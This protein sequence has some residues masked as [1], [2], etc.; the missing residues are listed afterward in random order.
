VARVTTEGGTV[1][2]E[3]G[4]VAVRGARAATIV[5]GAATDYNRDDPYKALADDPAAL[6]RGQ[7]ERASA[8]GYE[9]LKEASVADHQSLFRRVSLT[10]SGGVGEMV[11]STGERLAA[12]RA[13]ATDPGLEALYFQYGRYLLI[14]S[15]RPGDQPANLQGI[16]S[17]HLEAPWNAD[18]HVNINLQMNY[19]HAE[20]ANLA[21]CAD[22]FFWYIEGVRPAGREM[23]R[24]L[25]CRGFAMG[26][27]GD[28]W[29]WTAAT[30]EPVWGMWPQGAGWCATHFT[31][32][33]RFAGDREFLEKRAYPVLKEC[34]EFYL[35]WLEEEPGTGM[36]V[37][38]PE[39]SPEN[40]YRE[41]GKGLSQSM[42]PAMSQEIIAQVFGD[43]L[44]AAKALGVEDEFTKRVAG[45]MEKLARP[46]VG[47][48]GRLMEWRKEYE[49]PE[50]GHRHMS[51]LF[52]LYPGNTITQGKTPELVA[53]ARKSLD[54]RLSHGGGHT[55][56]SRAWLINFF[57]RLRDGEGAHEHLRLLLA[58][59]TLPNLFDD[60]PP[61]QIDGNFGG[62]AGI[63]EMLLQSH[64]GVIDV[65]PAL[66]KAWGQGSV[67]GLK[68]RGNFTVDIEWKG[69]V[70]TELAIRS[71]LGGPVRVRVRGWDGEGGVREYG[72][73]VEAKR[74]GNV[75]EFETKAGGRYTLV[76]K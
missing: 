45:A 33:W 18:Y 11:L 10:L 38:G 32:H 5:I 60:H 64:D 56:W 6:A 12:V 66:P 2:A 22:P 4:R 51:H 61:F 67:K 3:N 1:R 27:E 42:G 30:G 71:N 40:S 39:T 59:S 76:P 55:G 62:A 50:P 47:K 57:A 31:E 46:T 54:Y 72:R 13:G 68:A 14:C 48:D 28:A 23:A 15:S 26:H 53:A 70:V 74:L 58:K 75:I 63:A 16:W 43:M 52:G 29:L 7:V 73:R 17:E 20:V 41:G 69:G 37:S 35:D 8:K 44:E 36:L 21:E 19:W 34:A 25:G 9:A 49:E 65:L 24:R